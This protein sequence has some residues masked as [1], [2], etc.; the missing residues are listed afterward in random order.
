MIVGE[1]RTFGHKTLITLWVTGE[2]GVWSKKVNENRRKL[3]RRAREK[4]AI[5]RKE[6][7]VVV[8]VY[9][10]VCFRSPFDDSDPLRHASHAENVVVDDHM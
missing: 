9:M 1:C 6:G 2:N 3:S 4:W 8:V 10:N 5:E 7:V